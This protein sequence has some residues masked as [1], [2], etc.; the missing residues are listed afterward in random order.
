[1]T[2]AHRDDSV[3]AALSSLSIYLNECHLISDSPKQ[4]S[5]ANILGVISAT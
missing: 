3:L 5:D 2:I 1:M 4:V